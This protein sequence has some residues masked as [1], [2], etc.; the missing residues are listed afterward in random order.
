MQEFAEAAS[1]ILLL[2]GTDYQAALVMPFR[3]YGL[4]AER[5]SVRLVYAPGASR[6]GQV[7]RCDSREELGQRYTILKGPAAN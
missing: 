3:C 1:F 2:D 4:K 7:D 5:G 6:L